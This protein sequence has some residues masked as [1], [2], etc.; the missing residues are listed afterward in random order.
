MHCSR[1]FALFLCLPFCRFAAAEPPQVRYGSRPGLEN[2]PFGFE[3]PSPISDA[4]FARYAE[5]LQLSEAQKQFAAALLEEYANQCRELDRKDVPLLLAAAA[6]VTRALDEPTSKNSEFVI[7]SA[8]IQV[9]SIEA[10]YAGDLE[11]ADDL[12]FAKIATALTAE[13][14]SH[15]P[16]VELKRKR[17]RCLRHLYTL[18]K[19]RIDLASMLEQSDLP[20]ELRHGLDDLMYQY[21]LAATP[22]FVEAERRRKANNPRII[23]YT[24]KARFDR[25]GRELDPSIPA[26][27]QASRD[28]YA[29]AHKLIRDCARAELAIANL[30]D[31]WIKRFVERLPE[32]A[33][34]A[35]Q[36]SYLIAAYPRVYPD[37]GDTGA[38][39]QQLLSDELTQD[40]R[41]AFVSV[42]N[43]YRKQ[44]EAV[45]QS[46]CDESDRW[47]KQRAFEDTSN[48]WQEHNVLMRTWTEERIRHHLEF[49]E[50]AKQ[51]LPAAIISNYAE[52]LEDR[53]VNLNR[54]LE[55]LLNKPRD[56]P[57]A[58]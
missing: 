3:L 31:A 55:E 43:D 29:E 21:E 47:L 51:V 33:A 45:T 40:A 4:E 24:I 13:Q 10:R 44:I 50:R 30:N 39:C 1:T 42:V 19:A 46:M 7:S 23:E 18:T 25:A 15:I 26:V 28:A 9:R 58:W 12:L 8:A 34:A 49:I 27:A 22:L 6:P 57:G 41:T 16:Q 20:A 38:L 37:P 11:N 17:Q 48:G 2:C 52:N 5:L 54:Q 53:K 14:K 56:Y 35:L 36:L 32:S